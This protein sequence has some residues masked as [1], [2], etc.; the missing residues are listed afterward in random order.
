M[1]E[2]NNALNQHQEELSIYEINLVAS[3]SHHQDY[4]IFWIGN[5]YKPLLATLAGW[6]IF[7][8]LTQWLPTCRHWQGIDF[9]K[10]KIKAGIVEELVKTSCN[11][12][13][14]HLN[15]TYTHIMVKMYAHTLSEHC[16]KI[17]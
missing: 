14:N 2:N 11:Y 13:S 4:Y 15:S 6:G 3:N 10:Q 8:F 7:T 17:Q 9:P 12:P 5:P 16:T 1:C